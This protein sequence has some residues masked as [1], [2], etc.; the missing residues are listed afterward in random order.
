MQPATG[1]PVVEARRYEYRTHSVTAL[2]AKEQHEMEVP[3]EA[4]EQGIGSMSWTTWH[5][6]R[7]LGDCVQSSIYNVNEDCARQAYIACMMFE[8]NV[9]DDA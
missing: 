5:F 9:Q 6:E 3:A 1:L 2:L 7:F 4:R 8:E